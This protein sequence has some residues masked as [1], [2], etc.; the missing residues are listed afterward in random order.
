M[1]LH[2][3]SCDIQRK[4]ENT[5]IS[6]IIAYKYGAMGLLQTIPEWQGEGCAK[7][8]INN[9]AYHLESLNVTPYCFIE[10]GNVASE[11]LFKTMGFVKTNNVNMNTLKI[12]PA[13]VLSNLII[14]IIDKIKLL[15]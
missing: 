5:P 15:I 1:N 14:N 6:W 11:A 3:G 7:A 10:D 8:C 13:A 12:L 4:K 9:L 2:I